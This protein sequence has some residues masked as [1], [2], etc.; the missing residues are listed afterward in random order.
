MQRQPNSRN[1]EFQ[2]ST[3]CYIEQMYRL[4]F[5]RLGNAEDA[6][7]V[8]QDTYL[9]AFRSFESLHDRAHIKNWLTQILLN[10]IRDHYRKRSRSVDS[11]ELLETMDDTLQSFSIPGPEEVLSSTELDPQLLQA[12][13][14][15]PD[16]FVVPLLLREIYDATYEEI[17][18]VLDIPK[19]TVMSRLFRARTMLRKLLLSDDGLSEHGVGVH[20]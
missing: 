20:K 4:A 8:V 15:I 16:Q 3:L 13:H 10:N 5:A 18:H 12:L 14:A 17:A 6:R 11:V 19:G 7:D 9:K 2:T 1:D